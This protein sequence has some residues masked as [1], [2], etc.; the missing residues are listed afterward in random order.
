[1]LTMPLS[2]CATTANLCRSSPVPALSSFTRAEAQ[3]RL[4]RTT[5]ALRRAAV[6]A[7]LNA[8]VGTPSG[9]LDRGNAE[10]L[11]RVYAKCIAGQQDEANQRILQ[12]IRLN[13]ADT[14]P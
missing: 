1:M 13:V 12:A 9:R 6:S 5:C 2:T 7:W 4:A 14:N 8:G 3:A 10:V 11:L